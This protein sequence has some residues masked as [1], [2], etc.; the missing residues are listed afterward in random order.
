MP[1]GFK[2]FINQIGGDHSQVDHQSVENDIAQSVLLPGEHVHMAFKLGRDTTVFTTTRILV[3]DVHGMSGK[4]VEHRSLPYGAILTFAA[5]TAGGKLD[6]DAEL[7][8]W[9]R[10][11]W[12]NPLK[13]D[14]AKKEVEAARE[15]EREAGGR[16]C[17][18][19]GGG[20]GMGGGRESMMVLEAELR[21]W[22]GCLLPPPPPTHS[23]IGLVSSMQ[24][25]ST[26]PHCCRAR[27]T[28]AGPP[29]SAGPKY[30]NNRSYG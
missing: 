25:V 21:W 12:L 8:I 29:R 22:D 30:S 9:S 13:I 20:G 1:S 11:P 2:K 28:A 24:A 16:G 14:F 15:R 3:I 7:V 27:P 10:C 4:R 5:E 23:F 18:W 26:W 19:W 17:R 6:N